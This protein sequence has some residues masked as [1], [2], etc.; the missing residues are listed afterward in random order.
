MRSE[1]GKLSDFANFL[2]TII[3]KLFIYRG[4]NFKTVFQ[5]C[6]KH[7]HYDLFDYRVWMPNFTHQWPDNISQPAFTV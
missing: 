7:I 3:A 1:R 2:T 5:M 4:M 6:Q